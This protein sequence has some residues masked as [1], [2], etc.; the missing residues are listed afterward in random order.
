MLDYQQGRETVSEKQAELSVSSDPAS[1]QK[2]NLLL[3]WDY[4]CSYSLTMQ[5][6]FLYVQR[7]STRICRALFCNF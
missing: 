1:A 5:T 6:K 2:K 3:W 7:R 4:V